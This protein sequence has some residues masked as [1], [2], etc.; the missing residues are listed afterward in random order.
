MRHS[1]FLFSVEETPAASQVTK[2]SLQQIQVGVNKDGCQPQQ[3][4]GNGPRGW[5]CHVMEG[6]RARVLPAVV[7]FGG[8]QQDL[9]TKRPMPDDA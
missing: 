7:V 8:T 9:V 1:W 2:T 3:V 6:G 5:R 4:S